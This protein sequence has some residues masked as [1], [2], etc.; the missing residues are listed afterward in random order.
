VALLHGDFGTSFYFHPL[1]APMVAALILIALV[2]AWVWWRGSRPGGTPRPASW[3]PERLMLTPAPWVA[4]AAVTLVW[5][6]RLPL[7]VVG[8]WTF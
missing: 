5:L 6:V 7:Y 8:A 3:L 2:D 1:G 4:I